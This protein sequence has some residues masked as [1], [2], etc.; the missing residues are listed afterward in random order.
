[1][2][3]RMRFWA[4]FRLEHAIVALVMAL[5]CCVAPFTSPPDYALTRHRVSEYGK[6][7]QIITV[8]GS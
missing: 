2:Q 6:D 3:T 5:L 4:G 7:D 1:M 8:M